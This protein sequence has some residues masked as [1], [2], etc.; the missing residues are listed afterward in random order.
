LED[1]SQPIVKP[2]SDLEDALFPMPE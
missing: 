1:M 2:A